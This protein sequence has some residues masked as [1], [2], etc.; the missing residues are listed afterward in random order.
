MKYMHMKNKVKLVTKNS[1]TDLDDVM[2]PT[3]SGPIHINNI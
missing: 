3:D 2:N 1:N